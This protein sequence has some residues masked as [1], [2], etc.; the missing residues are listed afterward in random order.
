MQNPRSIYKNHPKLMEENK[1]YSYSHLY[2][3]TKIFMLKIL[4]LDIKIHY[5][6]IKKIKT[7]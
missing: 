7:N 2:S 6:S 1:I 5:I 4:M 3:L